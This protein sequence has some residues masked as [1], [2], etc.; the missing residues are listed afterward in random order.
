MQANLRCSFAAFLLVRCLELLKGFFFSQLFIF[1]F[2]S[3]SSHMKAIL[4]LLFFILDRFG[5]PVQAQKRPEK[6]KNK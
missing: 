1:F 5:A 3:E 4:R 6:D 2:T